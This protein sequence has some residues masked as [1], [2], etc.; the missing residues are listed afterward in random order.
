MLSTH[1]RSRE[2]LLAFAALILM[3][4]VAFAQVQPETPPIVRKQGDVLRGSAI[5]LVEPAYPPLAKAARVSGSVVVEVTVDE[6]GNV[7]ALRPVSGHPLLRDAAVAAARQWKFTP[8]LLSGVAVKVIGTLTFNFNLSRNRNA[9]GDDADVEEAKQQ[10]A[11]NPNSP[12]AH[13]TLGQA[14]A[15]DNKYEDAVKEFK[16]ALWL[17]PEHKPAYLAL[18]SV[19]RQMNHPDDEIANY[20]EALTHFPR[21]EDL[22]ERLV[23]ALVQDR[24]FAEAVDNQNLI[25]QLR[26]DDVNALNS[27][28]SYNLQLARF[29]DAIAAFKKAV[30]IR[31]DFALAH[32]YMGW[33][34]VRREHFEEALSAYAQ[35]VK[36]QPEYAQAYRVYSDM[37]SVYIRLHRYDEAE[38]ALKRSLEIRPMNPDAYRMTATIYH[39]TNRYDLAIEALNKGVGMSQVD[40]FLKYQLAEIYG[41]LG[42]F[43][44]AESLLRESVRLRPDFGQAYVALSAALVMQQKN[45]E[46]DK[47]LKQGAQLLQAAIN[48]NVI[49][50]QL[51]EHIGRTAEAV[52]TLR[53]ALKSDPNDLL[54][55]NNLGYILVQQDDK[56]E[57]GL[58]MIQRAVNASPK[59]GAYLDSLGWAYFKLGKLDEAERYLT[60]AARNRPESAAVQEHLGDLYQRQNKLDQARVQWQ[61]AM[62]LPMSG[63][64]AARLKG[65]LNPDPKK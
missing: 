43:S 62:T 15:E 7:I 28:G 63:T 38:A 27:L 55:L 64:Q 18:G 44:E 46:A 3:A 14:Y 48:P 45:D 25:V 42:R 37:A 33:A 10:V 11:A 61:R 53:L 49:L 31:P 32:H 36:V 35:A 54:V 21:A 57:E 41:H 60:E 50:A 23:Q 19:Y 40:P 24:R 56:L 12:D 8:T 13:V 2:W 34:N 29:D 6:Q 1:S 52:A 39:E 65:K 47:V 59:N 30:A 5:N 26:P 17:K 9:A 4:G 16:E 22:L 58:P 20:K 51:L